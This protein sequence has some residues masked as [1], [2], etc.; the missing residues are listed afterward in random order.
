VLHCRAAEFQGNL[1]V[2]CRSPHVLE[3]TCAEVLNLYDNLLTDLQG[4]AV[5]AQLPNLHTINLGR[6]QL[7]NLPLEMGNATNLTELWLEDNQF[8][9]FPIAV[10][11]LTQLRKLFLS[12]NQLS[13]VP[14]TL[15]ALQAL[16]VLSL[17]N[18]E[19]VEFPT[20]VFELQSLKQL[21]LRQNQMEELP[22]EGWSN[23]EQLQVLS[24][25]SNKIAALPDFSP[26]RDLKKVYLNGNRIVRVDEGLVTLD[27]LV[28]L[29]L[30]NN[31]I[32]ELPESFVQHFGEYNPETGALSGDKC[33]VLV[34]GNPLCE[35][36]HEQPMQL[37]TSST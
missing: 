23:L 11:Q 14:P 33:K 31:A 18:N 24:L 25:S 34:V 17:D 16:E 5:L 15:S 37:A 9:E 29:N 36:D 6:N 13:V 20:A 32:E 2:L 12:G 1:R 19:I 26:V 8:R 35:V 4:I 10:C 21:W 22:E 28:E 3:Q 7:M 27:Q 30:A